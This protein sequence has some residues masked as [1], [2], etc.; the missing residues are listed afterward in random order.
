M[1]NN[2]AVEINGVRFL[3]CTL[4]TDFLLS[5]LAD[6][7]FAMQHARQGMADFH[8]IQS[9]GKPFTPED[10]IALHTESRNWLQVMLEQPFSGKTVVITHHAPS[11]RSVHAR[12]MC[13]PHMD[14]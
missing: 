4:W 1:L 10:A 7:Y 8:I 12:G 3:G 13:Q 9:E 14:S 2:R 11:P 5:G 6:Q